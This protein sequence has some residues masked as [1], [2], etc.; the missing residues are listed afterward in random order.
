M[1]SISAECGDDAATR[2]LSTMANA[3]RASSILTIA[4]DIRELIAA[5][6]DV[7]N[8]TVGDFAPDQFPIP[9]RLRDSI[10]AS[11]QR[12]QT[13]YP[14]P[15]GNPELRQAVRDYV[16]RTQGMDYPLECFTILGGG[17]PALY[18]TYRL[19]MDPGELVVF[20]VP[21]WNNTNYRD[22]CQVRTKMVPC[23]AEDSFQPTADL[24]RPH[25]RDARL[26]VLNTPQNPSGG[27]MPKSEVE[28]FG[29]LLVEENERRKTTGEKPLY[30]LY[31]QIYRSIVFPGYQH[32]SPVQLVPE[33]APYVIH[34]DG[35]SKGYCA[36][37]LRCG[38]IFG[39]AAFTRKAIALLT[40]IG[41]W[42]PKPVQVGTAEWLNNQP[43]VDEWDQNLISRVRNRL[44][45]LYKGMQQI[46]D[47]GHPVDI[48]EPQGA[49]Y[50]S[51]RFNLVGRKTAAGTV[52][53]NNEDI[54]KYLLTEAGFALVPFK[55]FG[56]T[57]ADD[58]G[59]SRASVGAV[60]SEELQRALPRVQ[61]ALADTSPA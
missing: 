2:G 39:P 56:A 21:S 19:I 60:S 58:Q 28:A 44:D 51:V 16:K 33:C 3:M 50:L 37:G 25:L 14:P 41:A 9:E 18:A 35:I 15:A 55:A 46:R 5:G 20:P 54:R 11:L 45:V 36:T 29:H 24:L 57:D 43:A 38:W 22:V 31:D 13:N 8:L 49:I 59:W 40:H 12:G 7:A 53:N 47:A 42:A 27:V 30:L 23:R 17:R 61:Q 26:F 32:Y 4:N 10:Q 1:I 52:L 6:A 48:I 34:S